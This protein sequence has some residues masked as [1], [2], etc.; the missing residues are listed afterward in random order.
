MSGIDFIYDTN[1]FIYIIQGNPHVSHFAEAG[2]F[3]LSVISKLE[4]LGKFEIDT[5][6]KRIVSELISWG[7]VFDLDEQIQNKTIELKQ[8][9]KLKLPDAIIAAT[10]IYNNLPLVSADK[11][12]AQ[13]QELNFIQIDL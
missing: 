3:S 5:E 7:H 12:F 11:G 2:S 8:T 9:Y 6:E 1:I 10:A 13:I 4:L